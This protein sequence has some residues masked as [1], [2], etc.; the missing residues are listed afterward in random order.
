MNNL[1]YVFL[2]IILICV[3]IIFWL[4]RNTC[5]Y[6]HH[7]YKESGS[8][9]RRPDGAISLQGE[10]VKEDYNR[11]DEL[12]GYRFERQCSKC[13]HRQYKSMN[14]NGIKTVMWMDISKN[15]RS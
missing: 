9:S 15:S 6:G 3:L 8:F 14:I 12:V 4:K 11:P 2:I 1:I 7:W 10:I 13:K 5:K